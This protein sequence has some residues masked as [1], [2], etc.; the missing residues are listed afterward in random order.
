MIDNSTVSCNE[1]C[2]TGEAEDLKKSKAKDCFL[3][4]SC[5]ITE[6]EDKLY[7]LVIGQLVSQ[8]VMINRIMLSL[9]SYM[10]CAVGV[11]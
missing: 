11:S 1:S 6:A 8:S 4:S 10:L 2:L 5:L 7:A 9:I 3:L